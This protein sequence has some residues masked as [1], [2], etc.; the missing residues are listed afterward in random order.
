ML[1]KD[2]AQSLRQKYPDGVAN[3]GT[4]YSAMSDEDLVGRVVQKY[5]TYQSQLED[6][7]GAEQAKQDNAIIGNPIDAVKEFGSDVTKA[8]TERGTKIKEAIVPQDEK[9]LKSIVE[10]G[11]SRQALRIG[12]QIGGLVGDLELSAVKLIAP[13]FAEDLALKG[14]KKIAETDFIKGVTQKYDEFKAK[15]P[16]AAQDLEDTVNIAALIPYVKGAQKVAEV[17]GKAVQKVSK[18]TGEALEAGR[19]SRIANATKEIDSV[20]GSIVQGNTDDILKAKKALSTINT[21]GIKT[22][23]ELGGRIDDGIEALATKVDDMLEKQSGAMANA[24]KVD[25][26]FVMNRSQRVQRAA[27]VAQNQENN[28]SYMAKNGLYKDTIGKFANP[29]T[30]LTV[31]R[32]A[33][34]KIEVGDFVSLTEEGAKQYL[35]EGAGRKIYK[36]TVKAKDLYNTGTKIDY[37]YSPEGTSKLLQDASKL[38]PNQLVTATQV[39][40]KLVK[41]NFVKDALDQ[42]DELYVSIKDAPKRA[43][44]ANIKNKL[45]TEGLTL[46]EANDVSRLYG[47]EFGSKAFSKMGDPLT[48]INAQAFEN[49]RKGIKNVVRNLMPDETVKMLDQRMSDL[50][51]TRRLV[52]KMEEKVSALY[53]KVKKRGL[54]EQIAMKTADVANTLTMNTVSGFI[55][56]LLPS[57]V[58][59]KVMNSID[60]E[61]A[62]SDSLKKVNGLMRTTDDA[63]L[64]DRIVKIMQKNASKVK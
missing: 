21:T 55:S 12:G 19:V 61:K 22:Y 10:G 27:Q 48:S 28:L 17:G 45:N 57:N 5:P 16:E 50:Y 56:R 11:Q 7:K 41:Q 40:N 35:S 46:K 4:L 13:K 58:G 38:K 59:L 6:F 18:I 44:I 8:F 53:Q 64:R 30:K 31:Y 47:R 34:G 36:T 14:V 23:S 3:D 33:K 25:T 1:T 51:N 63:L 32:A 39:G 20:V 26:Q 24:G 49:T 42:L 2:F 37:V 54:L 60:L 52:G 9:G 43:E 62:L 15:H 29:D